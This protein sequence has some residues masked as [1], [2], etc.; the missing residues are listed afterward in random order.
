MRV[1][2]MLFLLVPILEIWFLVA[3]GRGIGWGPALLLCVLTGVI[4]AWLA[5]REGLQIFRLAQVQLSRGELPGEAIL[6]GICV[7]MGGLLLLAP[8]F[9][10]DI[11]GFLLLIP[12]I[13]GIAKL[14]IKRWLYKRIR[15][16]QLNI[17]TFNRFNRF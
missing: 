17:F 12:Y 7:F 16:G 8:G 5:K 1:L 3:A 10:S 9:L 15:N 11:V 4:G 14:F 13:R 2:I 6:D